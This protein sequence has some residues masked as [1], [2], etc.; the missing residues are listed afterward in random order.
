M[1]QIILHRQN[2]IAALLVKLR[3]KF[4]GRQ[5]VRAH[6]TNAKTWHLRKQMRAAPGASRTRQALERP[7][8]RFTFRHFDCSR[9]INRNAGVRSTM[10]RLTVVA[11]TVELLSRFAA[12]LYLDRSA[13]ASEL[14]GLRSVVARTIQIVRCGFIG[15]SRLAPAT[16][17]EDNPEESTR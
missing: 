16:I 7:C 15:A 8:R 6:G 3:T 10:R 5:K 2:G 13:Q 11:V 9:W 17:L 4:A 14:G 1:G 12:E